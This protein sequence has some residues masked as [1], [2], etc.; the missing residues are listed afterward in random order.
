VSVVNSASKKNSYFVTK[1]TM[2]F[3]RAVKNGVTPIEN[4]ETLKRKIHS[5]DFKEQRLLKKS[6][7]HR[8]QRLVHLTSRVFL[9]MHL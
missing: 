7:E 1:K 5:R 6:K 8:V 2:K 9:A 3:T 4:P